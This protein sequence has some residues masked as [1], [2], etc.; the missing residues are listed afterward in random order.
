MKSRKRIEVLQ[1]FAAACF[2][3][4]SGSVFAWHRL[5]PRRK[6]GHHEGRE[7]HEIDEIEVHMVHYCSTH[8]S[9]TPERLLEGR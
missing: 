2:Q 1:Q 3:S 6:H 4:R 9:A 5:H 7:I 8:F